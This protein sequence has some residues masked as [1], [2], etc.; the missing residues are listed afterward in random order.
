[1]FCRSIALARF[2][3][4]ASVAFGLLGVAALPVAAFGRQ[5]VFT[6]TI[7]GD[8]PG[9][10]NPF[11]A[12]VATR[13]VDRYAR[14]LGLTEDQK[15]A[16]KGMVEAMASEFSQ[17]S[18]E[19]REKMDEIQAE[20]QETRDPSIFRDKMP[21]IMGKL[22][23][24]RAEMEHAFLADFRLLLNPDQEARWGNLEMLRRREANTGGFMGMA[25]ESVD[26]VKVG[27]SVGVIEGPDFAGAG[28]ELRQLF[29]Q[30]ERE[31]D[32]ALAEKS[33]AM[34]ENGA[35]APGDGQPV[36]PE[37]MRKAMEAVREKSVAVRDVNQKY[38]RQIQGMLS[39]PSAGKWNDEVKRQTYPDVY[40]E[41]YTSRALKSALE[42]DDLS[43]EQRSTILSL[44]EQY[45]RELA[46]ANEALARAIADAD[47]SGERGGMVGGPGGPMMIRMGDEPEAVKSARAAKR[48]M[49]TKALDKLKSNLS[50]SQRSKL[51]PKRERRGPGR[52][53][54][55]GAG[56]DDSVEIHMITTDVRN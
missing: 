9:G 22:R 17:F 51:P 45:A 2:A 25:G 12:P 50:E 37:V 26:L 29:E 3:R 24:K 13:D 19:S 15:A 40:R 32:K 18:R 46:P 27:E 21:A 47:Q 5:M 52:A 38:A 41:T 44:Q 23:E 6:S 49:D 7:S 16:A 20:F 30:Y 43:P 53:P 56:E 54:A 14:L 11:R 55:D 28:P 31:L 39:E 48:D 4:T 35:R 1:M 36:D 8:G 33:R 10:G 42:L 34:N